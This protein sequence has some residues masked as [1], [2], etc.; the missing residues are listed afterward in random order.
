MLINI[1]NLTRLFDRIY[2]NN[3]E[4]Y[5]GKV[6]ISTERNPIDENRFETIDNSIHLDHKFLCLKEQMNSY[7]F[8][9]KPLYSILTYNLIINFINLI[10]RNNVENNYLLYRDEFGISD[11]PLITVTENCTFESIIEDYLKDIEF[12]FGISYSKSSIEHI[13]K[14]LNDHFKIVYN[15]YENNNNSKYILIVEDLLTGI[16]LH[17]ENI[18]EARYK[19]MLNAKRITS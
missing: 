14:E 4:I 17:T 12:R 8:R 11:T 1:S 15:F 7:I 19:E 9:D 6:F 5:K 18:Y 2:L 13:L 16:Y 10:V 3:N